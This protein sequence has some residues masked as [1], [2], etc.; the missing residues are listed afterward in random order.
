MNSWRNA[1]LFVNR[2]VLAKTEK[3]LMVNLSVAGLLLDDPRRLE[4]EVRRGEREGRVRGL[5]EMEI[6][7]INLSNQICINSI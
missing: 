4:V 3:N 6:F 5:N 1:F 2:K 7:Q